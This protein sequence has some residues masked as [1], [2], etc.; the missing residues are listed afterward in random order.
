ME[1]F[2]LF[3]GYFIICTVWGSTW[4]AMKFSLEHYPPFFATSVRFFIATAAL[5]ALIKLRGGKIKFEKENAHIFWKLTLFSYSLPFAMVFY[6]EQTV[7]SGLGAVLFAT[8]PFFGI[9]FSRVML[10]QKTDFFQILGVALGFTGIVLIFAQD[11]TSQNFS[12]LT[13]I[14]LILLSSAIQA[15]ISVY[16]KKHGKN[17]SVL[18]M[19]F[20][21]FLVSGGIVLIFSLLF[22]TLPN[23]LLNPEGLAAITYLAVFGS[24]LTFSTYYWLMKRMNVVILSLSSFITPIIAVYLGWLILNE[25]FSEN[26]YLASALVLLGVLLANFKGLYK[27]IANLRL[28]GEH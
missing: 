26:V 28:Q 7:S 8:F 9:I 2:K 21:P 17:V 13:G 1:K 15:Y 22:E 11:L 27:Y 14:L 20:Y 23:D 10:K 19:N 25:S 24:V 16:L 18:Q 5:Y 12:A 6:A 4:L 3:F